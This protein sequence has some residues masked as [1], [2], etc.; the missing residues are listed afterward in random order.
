MYCIDTSQIESKAVKIFLEE[1]TQTLS[2]VNLDHDKKSVF[3]PKQ[4]KVSDQY[5]KLLLWS[6]RNL[7]HGNKMTLNLVDLL[8]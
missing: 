1:N 8:W 5:M 2:Q 4:N 7:L 3:F 6:Y